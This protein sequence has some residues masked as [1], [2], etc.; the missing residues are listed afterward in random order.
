MISSDRAST[1]RAAPN[2]FRI[3]SA[4]W[5]ASSGESPL[6][7][8]A[9]L[10]AESSGP[11]FTSQAIR[12]VDAARSS[13]P[14]PP[15]AAKII[16]G[17]RAASSIANE[18]KNSRSMSIFS[19][20]STVSTG[21]CPTFIASI[22]AAWPRT[23]ASFLAKATPPMP[24]RPV[25]QAWILITTSAAFLPAASSFA[26]AIAWSAVEA[27]RPRGILNPLA[28]RMALP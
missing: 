3:D 8:T 6:E 12:R 20:T 27:A 26:T 16:I 5:A 17:A 10:T 2:N 19:S 13:I 18:R 1:L 25:V 22:C 14:L 24:A 21:N 11:P 23:S 28:A 15:P 9:S 7:A 4:S